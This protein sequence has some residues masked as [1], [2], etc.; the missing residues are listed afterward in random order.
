MRRRPGP[1]R[2]LR[3]V[4]A[5]LLTVATAGAQPK[6][7][8]PER[9]DVVFPDC[10][11]EPFPYEAVLAA[12]RVE[13]ALEGVARVNRL[14]SG[15][16][17]DG[18]R[19]VLLAD[20]GGEVN[21]VVV[22][23]VDPRTSGALRRTD[24]ADVPPPHRPRAVALVAA[25]LARSVWT[26][27]QRRVEVDTAAV[28]MDGAA[29]PDEPRAEPARPAAPLP[30]R[31]DPGPDGS[32]ARDA[33]GTGEAPA[34]VPLRD[35]LT[36]AP[37]LVGRLFLSEPTA[38]AGLGARLGWRRM[39]AGADG[40]AG[41]RDDPLG[42][43]TFGVVAGVIGLDLLRRE[44]EWVALRA[45]PRAAAGVATAAAR[46]GDAARDAT[47][48]EA[49]LDL[50]V[51]IGATARL[52]P[53]AAATLALEGGAARG[54]EIYADERRLDLIGGSFVGTRVGLELTP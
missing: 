14:P 47:A 26:R 39:F 4:I 51:E 16:G 8:V 50:A 19:I 21:A 12:L 11:R 13:L 33:D 34:A 32:G 3:V 22:E 18:A 53:H 29:L 45:G 10:P 36:L 43:V 40:L 35:S 37:A 6:P 48:R 15:D 46:A 9:V 44:G 1:A 25:E 23:V 30:T 38:L 42:S 27:P 54:L 2:S 7:L 5:A 49:Y 31:T 52:S 24:L 28:V 41:R 17:A 20:C